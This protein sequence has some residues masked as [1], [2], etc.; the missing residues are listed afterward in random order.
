MA[1]YTTQVRSIVESGVDL[2][3]FDYPIFDPSYKPVL[4]QKI[5]D[6]YYFREIG[7]ETVAQFK[8]F[9]KSKLN[10]ILP[11]YNDRYLALQMFKTY[12]PYNNKNITT[13]EKRT[14]DGESLGSSEGSATSRDVF[15]DTPQAKLEGLDYA[16][17]L[18][19]GEAS[20]TS[21]GTNNFS[22]TDEY[23]QTITG[24]DGMK[25]ASE[26]YLGVIQTIENLDLLII[27]E[28]NELF[29]SVY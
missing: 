29:M 15:S 7:F 21:S 12:D 23:V 19:D 13:T 26:V 17:N 8:H 24:F 2:F 28:L 9:L 16:T 11:F 6:F 3:D 1:R 20:S 18:S 4:E 25:Y 27:N 10:I 14:V 5:I 22:T